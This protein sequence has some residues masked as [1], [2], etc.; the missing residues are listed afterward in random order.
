[1][2]DKKWLCPDCG[3][4]ALSVGQ[5]IELPP[6]RW[7]DE[8]TLHTVCCTS[9]PFYGVAVYMESRRGALNSESW[10][11]YGYHVTHSVHELLRDAIA[12]CP[13]PGKWQCRC[14]AHL[15]LGKQDALGEWDWP[16][17]SSIDR[18]TMFQ[19][20]ALEL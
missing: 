9:C 12:Q 17:Q 14:P 5:G 4:A 2:S 6:D 8:I 18:A 1:M 10:K 19:I 7:S 11:H 16:R 15:L 20:S 3:N 13:N